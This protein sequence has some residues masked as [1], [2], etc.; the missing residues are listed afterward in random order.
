MGSTD[1]KV[2]SNIFRLAGNCENSF[3]HSTTRYRA[4]VG[5]IRACTQQ[6][7]MVKPDPG[8]EDCCRLLRRAGVL[9]EPELAASL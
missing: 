5:G 7:R 6:T 3:N 4:Q 1:R 2:G 9:P 8:V